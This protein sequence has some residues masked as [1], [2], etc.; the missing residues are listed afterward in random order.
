MKTLIVDNHTNHIEAWKKLFSCYPTLVDFVRAEDI[1][2]SKTDGYDLILLSG[3][4]GF[5]V[6]RNLA[7][8]Q[9]E[10]ELI[11]NRTKPLL[12]VCLGF[13]AII[14]A[15]GGELFYRQNRITG[16]EYNTVIKGHAIFGNKNTFE[17][18]VAHKYYCTTVPSGCE[19]LATSDHGIEILHHQEKPLYGFQ[20][21][22]ER[23]E[24]RND[25]QEIFENFM[26]EVCGV[27]K[28]DEKSI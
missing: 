4:V 3:G 10:L 6:D 17:T 24:P 22:P 19:V 1:D 14:T 15:L 16:I 11:K 8:F 5:A 23:F 13:E 20:F 21:H 27:L 2:L 9:K 18:Y 28:K 26:R 12:G 25:G 7:S